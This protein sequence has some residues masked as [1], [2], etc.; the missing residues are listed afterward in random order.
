M[1]FVLI[2]PNYEHDTVWASLDSAVV[3][4]DTTAGAWGVTFKGVD[5]L[6]K[7]VLGS[8]GIITSNGGTN[9]LYR[10]NTNAGAPATYTLYRAKGTQGTPATIVDGDDIGLLHAKGY[11]GDS[12]ES[13][14]QFL[15][16]AGTT[17]SDGVVPGKFVLS[18]ADKDGGL[19]TVFTVDH[20]SSATFAGDVTITGDL[21]GDVTITG[22]L[23]Y[24]FT[25]WVGSAD[26][27]TYTPSI[28]QNLYTKLTPAM[29]EHENDGMTY[30]AD[31]L[32][33]ISAGDYTI[34][35]SVRFSGANAND[36]WQI[37]VYKN[38]AAMGSSVGRFI[39][40]T[41]TA[42]QP[43]TRSYFWYLT[44]LAADDDIS[45]RMTNLTASRDPTFLDFKIY[46][47]KKPE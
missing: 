1:R 27:I 7:I 42:G 44:D 9:N 39:I 24:D 38:G 47:E 36:A 31:S 33:I 21:L 25:H 46:M 13:A 35:I 26:V 2:N 23:V 5:G 34:Q 14:G 28:T 8:T 12:Y 29:V 30:A 17:V 43:D 37:K 45:F 3:K 40:R 4:F 18:L 20:D 11:D 16:E 32:T 10:F 6:T 15:F 19:Q 41:N 22:D